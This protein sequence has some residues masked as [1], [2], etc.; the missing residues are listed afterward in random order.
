M[1]VLLHAGGG[2]ALASV[3]LRKC[4]LFAAA[5]YHRLAQT[6][7]ILHAKGQLL[8]GQTLQPVTAAI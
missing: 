6:L 2:G 4:A 1:A 5:I 3:H 7:N 8:P